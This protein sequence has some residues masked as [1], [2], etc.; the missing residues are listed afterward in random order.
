MKLFFIEA[1]ETVPGGKVKSY[2]FK[3]NGFI[4]KH[5]ELQPC[6]GYKR[7]SAAERAMA[8]WQNEPLGQVEF[9]VLA[10]EYGRTESPSEEFSRNSHTTYRQQHAR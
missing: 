7:E 4:A 8:M 1:T 9:S 5:E 6:D 2:I 3:R 10:M